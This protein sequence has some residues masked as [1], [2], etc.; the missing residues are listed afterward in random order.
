MN[1]QGKGVE[2]ESIGPTRWMARRPLDAYWD[3][4]VDELFDVGFH[5][6]EILQTKSWPYNR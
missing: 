1:L 5:L 4:V 2:R 6:R 3:L